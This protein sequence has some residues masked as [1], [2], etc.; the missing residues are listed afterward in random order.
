V[1][2]ILLIIRGVVFFLLL[3]IG[4]LSWSSTL[5][6]P[7][8]VWVLAFETLIVVQMIKTKFAGIVEIFALWVFK[9]FI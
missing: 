9:P 2:P 1:I 5:S 8:K 6:M 4:W 3:I 7:T